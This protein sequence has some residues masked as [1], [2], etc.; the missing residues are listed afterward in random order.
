MHIF[1]ALS[2]SR[3]SLSLSV[4]S[5]AVTSVRSEV[6]SGILDQFWQCTRTAYPTYD[7]FCLCFF[8]V[9]C[10]IYPQSLP[11]RKQLEKWVE[12]VPVG[13]VAVITNILVA[14]LT[15]CMLMF[16]CC[17]LVFQ[18]KPMYGFPL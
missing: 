3:L 8:V 2:L 16:T 11:I 5:V 12:S 17:E 7:I 15:F 10:I 18:V 14:V 4:Y 13:V 1:F 6:Y 9:V